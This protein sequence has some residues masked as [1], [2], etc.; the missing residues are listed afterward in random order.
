MSLSD[1]VNGGTPPAALPVLMGLLNQAD[2][3]GVTETL[4]RALTVRGAGLD[5]ARSLLRAFARPEQPEHSTFD[6]RQPTRF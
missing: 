5:V 3:P 4:V 1:Y 2:D 6:G